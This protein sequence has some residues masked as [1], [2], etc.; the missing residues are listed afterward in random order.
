MKSEYE[1]LSKLFPYM[2]RFFFWFILALQDPTINTYLRDNLLIR[3]TSIIDYHLKASKPLEY[4]DQSVRSASGSKED[5]WIESLEK[6]SL[7][8]KLF[9]L[10]SLAPYSRGRIASAAAT[11]SSALVEV[12][13]IA[14]LRHAVESAYHRR[15][16]SLTLP[17]ILAVMEVAAHCQESIFQRYASILDLLQSILYAEE[18]SLR[19][20]SATN[21]Q[22]SRNRIFIVMLI[23]DFFDKLR[24]LLSESKL[25]VLLQRR[26][27]ATAALILA[28]DASHHVSHG[29]DLEDLSF[30][31]QFYRS[32]FLSISADDVSSTNVNSLSSKKKSATASKTRS[33][34]NKLTSPCKLAPVSAATSP[35]PSASTDAFAIARSLSASSSAS[36]PAILVE[37]DVDQPFIGKT[38]MAFWQLHP[39]LQQVHVFLIQHFYQARMAQIK[40]YVAQAV[41]SLWMIHSDYLSTL[42]PQSF[43]SSERMQRPRPS[44]Y[45]QERSPELLAQSLAEIDRMIAASMQSAFIDELFALYPSDSRVVALAR[46]FTLVELRNQNKHLATHS[47]QYLRRKL[48]EVVKLSE[49]QQPRNPPVAKVDAENGS[50]NKESLEG[51]SEEILCSELGRIKQRIL[52]SSHLGLL[53]KDSSQSTIVERVK[54][55]LLDDDISAAAS[56]RNQCVGLMQALVDLGCLASK[57]SAHGPSSSP[58]SELTNSF[59]SVF[60]TYL[61]ATADNISATSTSMR[62]FLSIEMNKFLVQ[63]L[64]HAFLALSSPQAVE[65]C[66]EDIAAAV[67]QLIINDIITQT[68]LIGVF[69]ILARK[70]SQALIAAVFVA[71]DGQRVLRSQLIRMIGCYLALQASHYHFDELEVKMLIA[72]EWIADHDLCNKIKRCSATELG[73]VI[74]TLASR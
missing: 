7:L 41:R 51:R 22:L 24:E 3:I 20:T 65:Y 49:K 52:G 73:L 58:A 47:A 16:L 66:V 34:S 38:E 12:F 60:I 27:T 11:Q 32:S 74:T 53:S 43:D 15:S 39:P 56:A 19:S 31:R 59:L 18:F 30:S 9:G 68:S 61:T 37:E 6:L 48:D 62:D 10:I 8:G 55:I 5:L 21:Y 4:P 50:L 35:S 63:M 26:F 13:L 70:S 1:N 36:T 69:T 46:Q 44:V 54:S 2:Q 64:P 45:L 25:T 28:V 29:I 42:D 72:E 14:P 23:G 17:W 67:N 33:S 71:A 40:D 57:Y